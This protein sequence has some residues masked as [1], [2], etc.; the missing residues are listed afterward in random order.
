MIIDYKK[1]DL[2]IKNISIINALNN[3]NI[4]NTFIIDII[5]IFIKDFI[6][7]T[8]FVKLIIRYF[9]NIFL[10]ANINMI[11]RY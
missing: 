2:S 1:F 5:D 11:I 6:N 4:N 9:F 8:S 7:I 3:F 10:I